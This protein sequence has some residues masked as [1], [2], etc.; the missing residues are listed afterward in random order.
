M[1]KLTRATIADLKPSGAFSY[2][3][4]STLPGFGVRVTAGGIKSFIL[5]Y[6]INGRQRIKT[7]GRVEVLDLSEAQAIAR[8]RL[9]TSYTG[10]DPFTQRGQIE[11][12]RDL[13]QAFQSGRKDELKPKTWKGYESLWNAHILP[14]LGTRPIKGLIDE[15]TSALRRRLKK[16]PAT[17][18]RAIDLVLAALKW[19]GIPVEGH[20]FKTAAKFAEH[21]RER[22]L[23]TEE[24]QRFYK[25]FSEY[26]AQRLTGWRYVDL[27]ALLLLT[28]LR[29]DEWRLGRWEWLR[30]DEALYILPDN[31]TGGRT[32]VLSELALQ[33]LRDM[34]AAQKR[35]KSGFIFPS[36]RSK[37]KALSWTW[38]EWDTMRRDLGLQG[39]TVHDMRRTA[40]SKAHGR[41]GLSQ[42]QVADL[43][44]HKRLETSSRYIH[45]PEKRETANAAAQAMAADWAPPPAK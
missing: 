42:R 45:D 16:K 8:Q 28:A 21:Q 15:D 23:S 44:G 2:L 7:L 34:H 29:R 3:W 5:R 36:V 13:A 14:C 35:P 12:L 40:G 32:V 6:R 24:N 9:A 43:L 38:R 19:H 39:F 31:K 41:G 22:I 18:N 1:A 25:S 4:D 37:K 20:P 33:I 26:K 27:F 30:W 10:A 17:F 11:T